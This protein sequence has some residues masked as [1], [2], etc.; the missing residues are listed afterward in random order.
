MHSSIS[1]T[2]SPT[3]KRMRSEDGF[4]NKMIDNRRV[5]GIVP[6]EPLYPP[7]PTDWSVQSWKN[8]P[9]LQNPFESTDPSKMS[10]AVGRLER[11]PPLV[12]VKEV[13]QLR[14]LLEDVEAGRAFILQGG[15]C[16]ERFDDCDADLIAIKLKILLQMSL[17]ISWGAKKKCIKI[18][19]LAGQYRETLSTI[20]TQI[21]LQEYPTLRDW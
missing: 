8:F 7:T 18:G 11:L 20:S 14:T 12:D 10:S 21:L 16:A 6:I 1:V 2:G 13:Q 3:R 19:R 17:V 5:S 9:V 4:K 15:D